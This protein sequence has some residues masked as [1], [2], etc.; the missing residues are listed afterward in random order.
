MAEQS[1]YYEIA[2][3][4]SVHPVDFDMAVDNSPAAVDLVGHY[5]AAGFA[6]D[7]VG[8]AV[9]IAGYYHTAVCL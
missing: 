4:D 8:T 9:H 7:L 5:T 3:V 1:H 2:P 6:V